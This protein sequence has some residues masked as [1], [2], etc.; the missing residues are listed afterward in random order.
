MSELQIIRCESSA[1]FPDRLR[2]PDRGT[3][4]FTRA[5]AGPE[6]VEEETTLRRRPTED[7]EL[8]RIGSVR[9]DAGPMLVVRLERVPRA[10]ARE[11]RSD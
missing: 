2:C 8:V 9:L 11:N 4:N 3:S 1:M 10:G 7:G 6:L 5:H